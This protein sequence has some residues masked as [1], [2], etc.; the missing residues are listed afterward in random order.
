M[1][2]NV[3]FVELQVADIDARIKSIE[4][5]LAAL[6]AMRRAAEPLL[7]ANGQPTQPTDG[8]S[9]IRTGFRDS[10]RQALKKRPQGLTGKEIVQELASSGELSRYKGKVSPSVRVHN[11]LYGLRE[12]KE[13]VKV[14]KRYKL[15]DLRS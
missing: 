8:K 4:P 15:K 1:S 7:P 9:G 14:D 5:Q 3:N 13:V 12:K 6:Y 11:E 2:A 10:I